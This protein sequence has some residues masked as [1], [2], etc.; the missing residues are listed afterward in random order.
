MSCGGGPQTFLQWPHLEARSLPSPP[1]PHDHPY[2][3]PHLRSLLPMTS[4]WGLKRESLQTWGALLS[5]TLERWGQPWVWETAPGC[6]IHEASVGMLPA[7]G[8]Y[9][10]P[11]Q[12]W[13]SEAASQASPRVLMPPSWQ[14]APGYCWCPMQGRQGCGVQSCGC[15]PG[16]A[17]FTRGS[18]VPGLPSLAAPS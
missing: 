17:M 2:L 1:H 5:C 4:H 6:P 12:H 15:V 14:E 9:F 11:A 3:T 18:P 8:H 13:G 7:C 16:L 10:P